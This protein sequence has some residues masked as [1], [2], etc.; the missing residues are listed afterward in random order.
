LTTCELIVFS[1]IKRLLWWLLWFKH[2]LPVYFYGLP[3]GKKIVWNFFFWK[4]NCVELS[5]LLFRMFCLAQGHGALGRVRAMV[6]CASCPVLC[7]QALYFRI[8]SFFFFCM[9]VLHLRWVIYC[10]KATIKT[11]FVCCDWVFLLWYICC[12]LSHTRIKF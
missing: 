7:C 2:V 4:Q 10:P 9:T 6:V 3:S 12:K 1:Q 5:L 8:H 11:I